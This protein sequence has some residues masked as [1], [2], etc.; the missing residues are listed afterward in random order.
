[1]ISTMRTPRRGEIYYIDKNPYRPTYGSMQENGRPAI[2]VSNNLN[3]A[4]AL[5]YEVVYLTTQPKKDLPTHC[6]IRSAKYPSTALCEQ[7]TTVSDEQIRDYQGKCTEEEMAMVDACLAI[8]LGLDFGN[9]APKNEPTESYEEE[10]TE[11]YDYDTE[12]YEDTYTEGELEEITRMENEIEELKMA[13]TKAQKG[14]E[15]MKELY[16]DLLQKT[17]AR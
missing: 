15:L 8:S 10:E 12:D 9:E 4:H 1:M 7:I 13:L 2:I 11:G 14:E 3:N 6:T 5:T 16:N 17:I